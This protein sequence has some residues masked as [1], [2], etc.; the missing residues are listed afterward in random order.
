MKF[1]QKWIFNKDQ[2]AILL[3][4]P[5]E[6]PP[7]VVRIACQT[8]LQVSGQQDVDCRSWA[9]AEPNV[10]ILIEIASRLFEQGRYVY[11][12]NVRIVQICDTDL[13]AH[14]DRFRRTCDVRPRFVHF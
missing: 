2:S 9:D 7:V 14:R 12:Q 4:A 10:E 8:V 5:R 11:E 3:W 13:E 6:K 1:V